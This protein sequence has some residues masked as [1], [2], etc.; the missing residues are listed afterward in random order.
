MNQWIKDVGRIGRAMLMLLLAAALPLMASAQD[1]PK[2]PKASKAPK[3]ADESRKMAL[4]GRVVCLTEEVERRYH[5][6]SDCEHRGH[7]YSLKTADGKLHSFLP[8]DTAAAIYEDQRFRERELQVT[9]RPFP[10]SSFI[11]VIK[12][13]SLREGKLYDLY[14]FCEVCNIETHKPGECVC[15]HAPVEFREELVEEHNKR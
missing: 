11:E 12:L 5:V 8:T 13:Q 15:C 14:Y 4:R 6:K 3:V 1:K 2:A 10:D 9:A 7:V